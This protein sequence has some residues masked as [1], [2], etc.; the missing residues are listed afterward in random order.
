[1]VNVIVALNRLLSIKFLA[2]GEARFEQHVENLMRVRVCIV[3][4]S[5]QERKFSPSEK[6][7]AG[8][9]RAVMREVRLDRIR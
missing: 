8:E 3:K 1:V 7:L 5:I 2:G 9:I 6:F 4:R